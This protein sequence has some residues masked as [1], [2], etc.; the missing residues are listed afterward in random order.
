MAFKSKFTFVGEPSIAKKDPKK[1]AN[2]WKGGKDNDVDYAK[3]RFFVNNG[4]ESSAMVEA[5]GRSYDTIKTTTKDGPIEVHWANRNDPAIVE[6]VVGY[7]KYVVNLGEEKEF[8]T[9]Y[10]MICY[11]QEA[12]PEYDGKVRVTGQFVKEMYE[13]RL[14]DHFYIER[15]YA[16][17]AENTFDIE[18]DLYYNSDCV[19][20]ASLDTDGRVYVNGFIKQYVSGEGE[21]FVPQAVVA[22][23]NKLAEKSETA[24]AKM[25]AKVLM[26]NID[27]KSSSMYNSPWK[28]SFINGAEMEEFDEDMLTDE[29]KAM[30][31]VGLATVYDYKRG[32]RGANV[33]EF[34]LRAPM[35]NITGYENGPVDSGYSMGDIEAN[36]YL[37]PQDESAE[38]VEEAVVAEPAKKDDDSGLDMDD[39]LGEL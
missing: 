5:F 15:V 38:R 19:D 16:T 26:P 21:K 25:I 30:I 28:M 9:S 18:M 31:D 34:R 32:V 6:S 22:D 2:V 17:K 14:Y 8:I 7:R 39:L 10:D 11:L 23:F 29:Q 37:M 12:L 36:L 1:F 33:R 20:K 13:G 27:I 35:N 3:I 4:N 24:T